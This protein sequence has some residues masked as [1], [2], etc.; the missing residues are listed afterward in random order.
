MPNCYETYVNLILSAEHAHD[1]HY[2]LQ[3]RN[4]SHNFKT[5]KER[6]AIAGGVALFGG[7][8]KMGETPLAAFRREQDEE[9]GDLAKQITIKEV[10]VYDWG[11]EKEGR[12]K[13]AFSEDLGKV[14][15]RTLNG[16]LERAQTLIPNLESHLGF[17]WDERNP[18][19]RPL[20]NNS[21]TPRKFLQQSQYV[22]FVA[23]AEYNVL[24]TLA[25]M[26]MQGEP[27]VKEG[28][29]FIVPESA[30][31]AQ[32]MFPDDKMALVDHIS[33]KR[34]Q[35]NFNTDKGYYPDGK[36]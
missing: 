13:I 31:L 9:L 26:N 21:F 16:V 4:D 19:R 5:G 29:G 18:I 32:V 8:V 3:S 2:L 36:W 17:N 12:K 22:C 30:L 24:M 35:G 7:K 28:K 11:A 1:T 25:G 10:R 33:I 27:K 15:V 34:N 23:T 14:Y 20:K 6:F